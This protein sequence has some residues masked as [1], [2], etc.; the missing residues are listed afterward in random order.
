M[1]KSIAMSKVD[2]SVP[3][4]GFEKIHSVQKL[5]I[6]AAVATVVYFLVQI[7]NADLLT[8]LMTGWDTFCIGMI[9]M[10]W[11]TFFI[12]NSRQIRE[13]SK[14]QDPKRSVVFIIILVSTL[15]SFL[16]VLLL[17]I[18]RKSAE[19]GA[20]RLT[21]AIAGMLFSWFLIHTIFALRYAHIYYGDHE[22]KPNTHAGGL[23]FPGDTK[24]EY[25][26]FAYFSFVLGMTFQVSDV[27]ITSSRF[28]N[29]A[30]LHGL[31]SFGFNTIM[32]ALTINLIAGYGS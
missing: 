10:S 2:E 1:H 14:I 32:I 3:I 7:K 15:A 18:S 21:V 28:R 31:L 13:Q 11:I 17:I 4:P 27:Q 19:G 8:R 20:W 9:T 26:D 30:L 23:S 5:L 12:T 29:L 16:A 22:T 25:L 6:C 24:P